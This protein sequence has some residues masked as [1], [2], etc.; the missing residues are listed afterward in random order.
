MVYVISKD[1]KPLMPCTNVIARLLLKSGKARVKRRCPFTIKLNYDTTEYVQ[2]LTHGIDT[3]SS[4]I[5]SAVSDDKGNIYYTAEIEVRNDI[6]KKMDARREYRRNRRS[7]KTRYRKARFDNRK[8][9]KREDRLNPTM[10]SKIHSHEKEIESVAKILPI[11]RLV[12][13][14]GQFD[15]ASMKDPSIRSEKKIH[16]AYQK[17]PNYGYANV[18]AMVR[19]RDHYTCQCCGKK[20]CGLEVHHIVYRSNGGSDDPDNLITLCENCHKKVHNGMK[21]SLRGKRSVLASASQ[22]NVIRSRLLKRC[23]AIETY[24]YV[25]SENRQMLGLEKEHYIDACVIAS[26]GKAIEFKSDIVYQKKIVSK[27]DYQ[28]TK[29]VRS[30]KRVAPK[31]IYGFRKYDKV[32]YRGEEYFIK[33]RMTSGYAVLMDIHG[34]KQNFDNP[35]TVKLKECK[36]ISAR[37]G[38]LIAPIHLTA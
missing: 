3:G 25:T 36:R 18:K 31:K 19:A 1:N 10:T 21:L 15:M 33:G 38:L 7:R 16:W 4:T 17:G 20:G 2:N 8:N 37:K 26:G 6:K 35:K 5:G 9:S 27:G 24:G 30:E 23:D 13:E 34:T 12:L 11:R 22:M 28:K 14:C 29:G 32:L